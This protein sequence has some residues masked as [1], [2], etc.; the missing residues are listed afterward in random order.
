MTIRFLATPATSVPSESAFSTASYLLRKQRSRLSPLN[1]S[2][3]VFLKD[4]MDES[5]RDYSR[6]V[7]YA[8]ASDHRWSRLDLLTYFLKLFLIV[9]LVIILLCRCICYLLK[10]AVKTKMIS[11]STNCSWFRRNSHREKSNP[12]LYWLQADRLIYE[13]TYWCAA[14]CD[15]VVSWTGVF[16]MGNT[17]RNRRCRLRI[18]LTA[19]NFR[20]F[21]SSV[22]WLRAPC[23]LC[24][25]TMNICFHQ[26]SNTNTNTSKTNTSKTN[27]SQYLVIPKLSIPIPPI[28]QYHQYQ[29]HQYFQ[30]R[31]YQY[32]QYTNTHQ[33]RQ[34]QFPRVLVLRHA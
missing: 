2:Y 26:H 21:G 32:Y 17:W 24:K 6:T 12:S 29:C 10:D 20:I 11:T 15:Y 25:Y 9:F 5:W 34:Y 7:R 18:S 1:L 31:Q 30:Y 33:S 28:L 8:V 16:Q 19:M 27:T 23:Y 14:H 4:K 13:C 3:S 22:A